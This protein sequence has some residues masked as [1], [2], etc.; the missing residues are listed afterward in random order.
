MAGAER[1]N[2]IP[3]ANVWKVIVLVD[4]LLSRWTYKTIEMYN[5][6]VEV[7]LIYLGLNIFHLNQLVYI[8]LLTRKHLRLPS[9]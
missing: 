4:S 1:D 3:A 8:K 5:R 6:D 9:I 2:V 7:I